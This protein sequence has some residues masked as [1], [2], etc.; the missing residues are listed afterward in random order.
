MIKTRLLLLIFF[1]V[2]G[3]VAQD[4]A[5]PSI[6]PLASALIAVNV[7]EESFSEVD[8]STIYPLKEVIVSAT[9]SEKSPSELGRSVTLI[10]KDQMSNAIYNN[11]SELLSQQEGVYIVG[12]GQNPGMLQSIFMRGA[13]SN[14]TTIMVDEVRI[15]DPST[16]TNALDLSE[17]SLGGIDRIEMVRGSHSTLYGS[18]AIGGVVNILTEKNGRPGFNANAEIKGGSFGSGTST[19]A[20]NVSLNYTH[21]SGFYINSGF[22]NSSTKGLDATVD[23]VTDPNVFKHRDKDGF[24]IT[25]AF[26]KLGF[27][28]DEYDFYASY[29]NS[30]QKT[31]LDKGAYTDDDNYRLDF[32]RELFTYGASDRLGQFWTIKFLGG[33]STMQRTSVDDSSV[34]DKIGTTDHTYSNDMWKGTMSTNE[35]QANYRMTGLDAVVGTGLSS[36]TMTL[37]TYFYSGSSGVFESTTDLDTLKPQSTIKTIFARVDLGGELVGEALKPFSLALGAR[38]NKHSTYGSNTTYE[39]NPTL[40]VDELGLLYASY[41]SGFN[42]PSLYEI[43]APD[44]NYISGIVRG[45]KN[46]KPEIS[47]SY[48]FGFK[49]SIGDLTFS[50]DYFHTIVNDLIEDVYLWDK[51][52]GIDTLGNDYARDDFRGDTYINVGKQTTNGAELS[53]TYHFTPAL[54]VLGNFSLIS[55]TL[56]YTP[57]NINLAQTGGNRVQLYSNGAFVTGNLETS[58]LARRPNTGNFGLIYSPSGKFKLRIDIRYAGRR[59]DVFYDSRLGPYGALGTTPIAAYAVTDFSQRYSFNESLS[60]LGR[61]ENIFNTKY[62]EISGFTT[63]G[64]GV[65]VALRYDGQPL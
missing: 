55:G 29:K 12:T 65:Y 17:L 57:S 53:L 54:I 5:D 59:N 46:L 61:F 49:Q 21:Q 33:Y 14:Q 44:K 30:F 34:V 16:P 43:Y 23:T 32:R 9:R 6:G 7:R 1:A 26:G 27:H 56:D 37:R 4:A 2:A 18:S 60:I 39:V 36:E 52:I 58:G 11:V 19:A 20:E 15:T 38:A 62:S 8:T 35:I 50:I 47:S 45:N 48:E 13:A 28:D 63:R 40:K 3:A 51:N 42:A 25:Y 10:P 22:G 41:S 24:K 64:R 31:D